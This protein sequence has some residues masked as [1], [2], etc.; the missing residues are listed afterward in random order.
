[1]DLN[2]SGLWIQTLGSVLS[3]ICKKCSIHCQIYP[4]IS[5]FNGRIFNQFVKLLFSLSI[6]FLAIYD[7][8]HGLYLSSLCLIRT[9]LCR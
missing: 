1:M 9:I 7:S 3:S 5:V 4:F 8:S 2:L 6:H